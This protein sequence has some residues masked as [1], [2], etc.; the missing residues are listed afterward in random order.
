MGGICTGRLA[1][2]LIRFGHHL[3]GDVPVLLVFGAAMAMGS[4]WHHPYIDIF[5]GCWRLVLILA[6]FCRVLQPDRLPQLGTL[7]VFVLFLP[8]GMG[9]LNSVLQ[10]SECWDIA[11]QLSREMELD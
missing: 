5:L 7:P 10:M 1:I 3:L 2:R 8:E 11:L 9:I 4:D 6:S